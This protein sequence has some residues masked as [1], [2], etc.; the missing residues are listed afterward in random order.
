MAGG[1]GGG[2]GGGGSC[3]CDPSPLTTKGDLFTYSTGG[4]RLPVGTD[5]QI[6]VADSTVSVGI[7]WATGSGSVDA[8]AWHKTGDSF[9]VDGILGTLDNKLVKLYCNNKEFGRLTDQDGILSW[10]GPRLIIGTTTAYFQGSDAIHVEKNIPDS[11]NISIHNTYSGAASA[12][13]A[14]YL[15]NEFGD[16]GGF[17]LINGSWNGDAGVAA[18]ECALITA[19]AVTNLVLGTVTAG[20][21]TRFLVKAI[22]VGTIADT[23]GGSLLETRFRFEGFME[24]GN[25]LDAAGPILGGIY[26]RIGTIAATTAIGDFRTGVSAAQNFHFYTDA[27]NSQ[28]VAVVT[29]KSGYDTYLQLISGGAV[30]SALGAYFQVRNASGQ[31]MSASMPETGIGT[32]YLGKANF[33]TMAGSSGVGF[34]VNVNGADDSGWAIDA[35]GYLTLFSPRMAFFAGAPVVQQAITGS[36]GGNAALASLLTALGAGKYNLIVDS[37]SA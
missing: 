14:V 3:L 16:I 7:R 34:R 19:G 6:I 28:I 24:L 23:G 32:T 11:L 25:Y 36:R 10:T 27:G 8:N 35:N 37:T 22:E 17:N 15:V 29:G 31:F 26:G 30:G 5:G 2:G 18:R 21:K 1:G 12:N 9:G 20:A 13:S 33:W 4:A